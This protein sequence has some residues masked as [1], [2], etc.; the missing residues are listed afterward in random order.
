LFRKILKNLIGVLAVAVITLNTIACFVPLIIFAFVKLLVPVVTLRRLMTRWIM[1]IGSYWVDFNAFLLATVNKTKWDI[2]GLEGLSPQCW[3]LV[4][5][6]HQTWTD[7]VVLQSLFS[8]RI[9]F[10]KFFIK[11]QLVW[12]P[13]LGV[14]WWAMDMPFMKRYSKSHLAKHPEDK[15]KDLESTRKACQ[16]F[17]AT[18]TSVINFIEGTRFSEEKK[19]QR[20]SPY[21]HLLPPRAGGIALAISSMGDMFDAIV[22]VTVVYPTGRTKFW[23]IFCGNFDAITLEIVKRPIDD[24]MVAGDYGSDREFR[25]RFH[26][27]LTD[28]WKEKDQRIEVL[29]EESAIDLA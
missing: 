12:F 21:S 1:G 19:Q 15:G 22:D 9:P 20:A 13:F 23:D 3:Y 8:R 4:I 11:Q 25:S 17:R 26:R 27:W 24:W 2:R 18:P 6:N 29:L 16:K 14:A 5:A 28:V 7:I 10:L